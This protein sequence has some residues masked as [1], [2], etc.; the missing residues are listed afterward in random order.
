MK[1]H[2]FSVLP[3]FI[4]LGVAGDPTTLSCPGASG[5]EIPHPSGK[6]FVVECN[7]SHYGGVIADSNRG[8]LQGDLA[9]CIDA[10]AKDDDCVLLEWD[11]ANQACQLKSTYGMPNKSATIVA[12]RLEFKP[13][14]ASSL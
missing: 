4:V 14:M 7:V 11:A 12:A 10:C 13:R 2:I 9:S 8:P 6:S 3:I 1:R 5:T